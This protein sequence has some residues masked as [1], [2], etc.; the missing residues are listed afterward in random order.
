M[1][2]EIHKYVPYFPKKKYSM[3]VEQVAGHIAGIRHY[4]NKEH[5]SKRRYKSV[6]SGLD[7]FAKD[8]LLFPLGTKYSYSS[9]GYNLLSAV[10]EGA[11]KDSFL[12]FI[13]K[14]IF[15]ELKMNS[16]SADKNESIIPNRTSF[17]ELDS[18]KKNFLML[19]I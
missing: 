9:Y 3:T 13:K 6:R 19:N 16:I 7:I 2:N 4:R 10:V 8:T 11:S 15:D 12:N 18:E 14:S 5:L 1:N 17:Y